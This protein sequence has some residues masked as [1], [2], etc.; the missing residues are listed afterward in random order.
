[1]NLFAYLRFTCES[2]VKA[3]PALRIAQFFITRCPLDTSNNLSPGYLFDYFSEA[4]FPSLAAGE[5]QVD[6]A[7]SNNTGLFFPA[8]GIVV[9]ESGRLGESLRPDGVESRC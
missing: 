3:F 8:T 5:D 2:S 6:L 7:P 9:A 1:M 4:S